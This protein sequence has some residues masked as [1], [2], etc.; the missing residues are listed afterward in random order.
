MGPRLVATAQRCLKGEPKGLKEIP[1][2][3][4]YRVEIASS[5]ELIEK[6]RKAVGGFLAL[7]DS[8]IGVAKGR[9]LLNF[10]QSA[11]DQLPRNSQGR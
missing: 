10:M 2:D 8:P 9:L 6:Q 7:C 4:E 1:A 3:R 11:T 5:I